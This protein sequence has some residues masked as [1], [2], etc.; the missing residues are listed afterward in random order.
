MQKDS[1]TDIELN[2]KKKARRRLVGAIALVLL[3]I[4]LLPVLLKDRAEVSDQN[5]VKI[6][7]DNQV[8]QSAVDKH[9]AIVPEGF[10]SNVVPA[11]NETPV[12][13]LDPPDIKE[14]KAPVN[15][16][17]SVEELKPTTQAAA[18][19]E[20]PIIPSAYYVQVGVFSDPVNVKQLQA[21]LSELGY[22]SKTEKISTDKGEKLRLRTQAFSSRNEAAIALGN[23]KDAGL[24]GMVVSQ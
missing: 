13:P 16:A 14:Q 21:K 22:Q 19:T 11:D 12:K 20:K 7:I 10:D 24:T 1:V 17:K 4:V 8:E 9:E 5:E 15:E 2:L 23:I 18:K 3:M 6:T